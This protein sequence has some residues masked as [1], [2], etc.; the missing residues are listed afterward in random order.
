MRSKMLQLGLAAVAV[1]ALAVALGVGRGV[2]DVLLMV[3]IA[4]AVAGMY[5]LRRYA[6]TVLVYNRHV[7][8][9][10][11]IRLPR[12][13]E[14]SRSLQQSSSHPATNGPHRQARSATTSRQSPKSSTPAREPRRT[15]SLK[16][17]VG[18]DGRCTT[19]APCSQPSHPTAEGSRPSDSA[20][21]GL[22][23]PGR[24]RWSTSPA[25]GTTKVSGSASYTPISM[26]AGS[27]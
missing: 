11:P 1:L 12:T 20:A 2:I 17:M 26:V 18:S 9:P 16:T 15:G 13:E 10:A 4:A 5:L 21:V 3:G 7:E 14:G 23:R 24:S 8:S 27:R 25:C 6:R 19:Q 22:G